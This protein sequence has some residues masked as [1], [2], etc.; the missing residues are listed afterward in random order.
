MSHAPSASRARA[1]LVLG[2][3]GLLMGFCLSRIGFASW[4]EVH[5][6]FT[7]SS[8]RLI[9]AFLTGVLVLLPTW[10]LI[11]RL[12]G[13]SWSKRRIHRGTLIGGVLFGFGWALSG[14]CPS[15]ALVQLGEGQLGALLTLAGIFLGNLTYSVVHDRYF[16][17][18]T[19]SC[20]DV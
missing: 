11:H 13:A 10:P 16:R 18:S 6:M 7:F 14:A 17:W 2:A 12:T 5:A 19:Q 15:I 3:I 4:D 8:L 1:G 20:A 9:L